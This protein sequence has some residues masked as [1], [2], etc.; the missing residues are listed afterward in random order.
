MKQTPCEYVLWHGLPVLR[1]EIARCMINDFGLNEKEA[2]EKLGV[3]PAA[4]SQYLSGKRGKIDITDA[5]VLHEIHI[6]TK[7]IIN[8]GDGTVV[9]EICRLCKFFSYKKVFPFICESCED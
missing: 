7:R 1:K 6:S 5:K 8:Q 4:V 3:S 2:A 9:S